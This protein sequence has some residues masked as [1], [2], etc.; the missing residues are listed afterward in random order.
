MTEKKSGNSLPD[1]RSLT[2]KQMHEELV[3]ATILPL[4]GKVPVA[5]LESFIEEQLGPLTPDLEY[6]EGCTEI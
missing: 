1:F 4:V 6:P 3:L 5:Q 2:R